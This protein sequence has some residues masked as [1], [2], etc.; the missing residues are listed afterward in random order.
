M[1][2]KTRKYKQK[3]NVK[4]Q[5]QYCPTCRVPKAECLCEPLA[6]MEEEESHD[7]RRSTLRQS[8]WSIR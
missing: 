5:T 3:G 8:P 2:K 1:K 7:I 6:R 4:E